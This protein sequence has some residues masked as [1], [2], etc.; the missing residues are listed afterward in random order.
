MR[1]E[2]PWKPDKP[3][4]LIPEVIDNIPERATPMSEVARSSCFV[5]VAVVA[6]IVVV[7][8]LLV[9]LPWTGMFCL[10]VF[11]F[12]LIFGLLLRNQPKR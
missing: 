8:R 6:F 7:S 12:G 9:P 5:T 3:E 4:P 10:T 1:V 11:L 2:P